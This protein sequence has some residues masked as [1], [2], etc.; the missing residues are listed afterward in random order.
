MPKSFLSM[1]FLL[2]PL[3]ASAECGFVSN[4]QG[5]T[6]V[7]GSKSNGCFASPQFRQ[8]FRENLIASVEAMES[9][10]PSPQ[11]QAQK[12]SV[13]SR[14]ARGEKLWAIAERTRPPYYGQR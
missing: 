2:L 14:S 8:S 5:L 7:V 6:I 9:E 12:K 1:L 10:E 3:A 4:G 13:V 11:Q